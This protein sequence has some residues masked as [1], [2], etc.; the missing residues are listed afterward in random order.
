MDDTG[1]MEINVFEAEELVADI[2]SADDNRTATD[3]MVAFAVKLMDFFGIQND[4]LRKSHEWNQNKHRQFTPE[5]VAYIFSTDLKAPMP[6]NIFQ[7]R[8]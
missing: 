5:A 2:D 6:E 7:D 8:Q 3:T 1:G 4:R